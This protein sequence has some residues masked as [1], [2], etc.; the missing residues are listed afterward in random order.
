MM[1]F[2]R[3]TRQTNWSWFS[4]KFKWTKVQQILVKGFQ[5]KTGMVHIVH[6]LSIL[7][8]F[9]GHPSSGTL[10]NLRMFESREQLALAEI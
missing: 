6:I 7:T 4:H 5:F 3:K 9:C 1:H 2:K 8:N 10:L